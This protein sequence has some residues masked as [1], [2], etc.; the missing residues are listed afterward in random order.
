MNGKSVRSQRVKVC[1]VNAKNMLVLSYVFPFRLDTFYFS[2][3]IMFAHMSVRLSVRYKICPLYI[4][5]P[6]KTL[7]ETRM[8]LYLGELIVFYSSA[9]FLDDA[10]WRVLLWYWNLN[11]GG[12][13]SICIQEFPS[14]SSLE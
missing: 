9:C 2:H 12:N 10:L 1:A 6:F 11:I 7:F 13:S 8:W 4:W 5:K 3:G 14:Y